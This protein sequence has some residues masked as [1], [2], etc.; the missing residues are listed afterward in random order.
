M[1]EE[2]PFLRPDGTLDTAG[3]LYVSSRAIRIAEE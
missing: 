3:L 1:T 2:H